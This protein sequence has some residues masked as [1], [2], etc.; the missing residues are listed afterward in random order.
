[1]RALGKK[2]D[3]LIVISTS[4]NSENIIE[5]LKESKKLKIK[6]VALLGGTGG[7]AKKLADYPLIVPSNVTATIQESHIF[8][9]HFIFES[10][11]NN[12]I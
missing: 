3:I 11:D 9:G 2:N 6:S 12:L 7:K 1:M 4:G 10:V 8:L 5:V